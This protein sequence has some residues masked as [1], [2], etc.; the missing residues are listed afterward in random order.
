MSDRTD[1][2]P[3][4]APATLGRPVR[5]NRVAE[6]RYDP[7]GRAELVTVV[8]S[9]VADADGTDPTD[10]SPPLYEVIDADGIERAFFGPETTESARDGTARVEF[11]HAEFL[12]NVGSDGWVRVFEP[13]E[14][15]RA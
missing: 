10:L 15:G 8:V 3:A 4:G 6:R 1:G 14:P 9:A 12:V 7:Q 2:G 5:W 11:R 13:T